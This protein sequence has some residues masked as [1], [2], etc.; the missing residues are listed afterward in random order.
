MSQCVKFT[1][2]VNFMLQR[3]LFLGLKK[4]PI[5]SFSMSFG[6]RLDKDKQN[7]IFIFMGLVIINSPVSKKLNRGGSLHHTCTS[8]IT[9]S[10]SEVVQSCPTLCDPVDCSLPGSSLHGFLQAKILEWVAI[11]FSR[12]SSWPRDRI[13]VSHTGGRRFNLWASREDSVITT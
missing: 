8:V 10:E 4:Y 5:M 12:G 11:S 3:Q 6:C 2:T 13:W 1:H 7:K 9:E